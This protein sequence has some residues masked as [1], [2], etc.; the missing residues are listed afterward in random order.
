MREKTPVAKLNACS[1]AKTRPNQREDS[2]TMLALL[3][4]SFVEYA[5]SLGVEVIPE[6]DVPGHSSSWCAGEPSVCPSS[7]PTPLSP[8]SNTT[9]G[10]LADVASDLLKM[11]SGPLHFGGDEVW[12]CTFWEC[13]FV[14]ETILTVPRQARDTDQ[15]R[16]NTEGVSRRSGRSAGTHRRRWLRG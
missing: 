3:S 1:F 6:I 14:M 11:F 7:C 16:L 4:D 13:H 12:R 2:A 9:R 15:E 10:V 5:A 8:A